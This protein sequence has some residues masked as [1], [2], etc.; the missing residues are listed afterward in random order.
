MNGRTT[1]GPFYT[2]LSQK[3][4]PNQFPVLGYWQWCH[5]GALTFVFVFLYYFVFV[6]QCL[7]GGEIIS[8]LA[9]P[10]RYKKAGATH[11][12]VFTQTAAWIKGGGRGV[13]DIIK[14]YR[15]V[16]GNR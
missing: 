13:L 2:F 12:T 6:F 1:T 16:T 4:Q 15:A 7:Q 5:S 10:P 3:I 8:P 11:I 9:D 14:L